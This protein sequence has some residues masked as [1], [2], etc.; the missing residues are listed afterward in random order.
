MTTD[1]TFFTNEP[2]ATLLDRFKRT[3]SDVQYFDV[4]VGYFRTSGFYQL[5]DALESVDHIRILV[6]L[7]VDQKAFEWIETA[8]AQMDLDFESHKRTKDQAREQVAAEITQ[9]QDTYATE[10]G[11]QKFIDFIRSGKLEI[12]AYPSANLHAKVYISRFGEEDRDFGR[13]ITGSSNFSWSGLV[14]NREFNVEL[15]DRADVEFALEQFEALWAEAV[16]ISADY[17]ATV[18][19]QTWL[20]DTITP[21]ELYLKFLYEYLKEDINLDEDDLDIYLPDSFMELAYQKQAV[22]SAKKILDAYGGV[23]LADVVGLGKTYISALLAQQIQG[24]ILVICPPVLQ[25]YWRETFYDF[26]I[27]GYEVE[28]LGKLDALLQRDL[29]KFRYVLIDEAHRFR[30]EGT[31]AYEN[32]F[33]ICAGKQVILVSATPLNNRISDI[34]NQLKLFQPARKSTIPGIANL[35]QFFKALQ[36]RLDQ[37]EKTDPEYWTTLKAVSQE[38]RTKVLRYVMVRRT[39]SEILNYF[40]EDLTQQGLMFPK[41]A[42]PQKIIYQFDDKTE[43]VFNQT[44]R[45]LRRLSYA[46]YTPLLYLNQQVSSFTRQSQRNIGGFMR[47]ILVKRLE[48]SFYAFKRTL[49]RFIESY[50]KFIAM[51]EQ[52]TV[53]IS[54]DLD[55]YDLLERDNPDELLTEVEQNRVQ[56]YQATD[57]NDD[58]LQ[59]LR[60]DLILLQDIQTLWHRLE[61][62]PKLNQFVADLQ[63]HSHL[64]DQQLVIFTESKETG[65]HLY[66]TLDAKFPHQVMFYASKGGVYNASG[67]PVYHNPSVAKTLIQQNFDPNHSTQEDRIRIL[68]TTDVLAEGINLHRANVVVNYDLPWNPTRVLQRVGRVNR[69]GTAHDQVYIFNCFPTAQSEAQLGLEENIVAKIQAFHDTLGEDAKYLSEEEEVTTHELFGDRLYHTLN[70]RESYE[71][72]TEAE[73]RSELEYLQLLRQIRDQQPHLFETIKKLPRKA[74][75]AQRIKTLT[76]SPSPKMGEGSK[77]LSSSLLSTQE[78]LSKS[79]PSPSLG[80]GGRGDEGQLLASPSLGEGSQEGQLLTFFRQGALKKFFLSDG[81]TTQEIDFF[82]AVDWLECEPDHPKQPIPKRYYDLLQQNKDAF[83][84]LEQMPDLAPA[85]GR[86]GSTYDKFVIQCLKAKDI[87]RFRGFTDEDEAFLKVVRIA[88]EEGRIPK[89]TAKKVQQAIKPIAGDPLKLLNALKRTV[90]IALLAEPEP[91]PIPQWGQ[92]REVVLSEYL[93][94]PGSPSP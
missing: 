58:F 13:V 33:Q 51:V 18:Q 77:K 12:K 50:E 65:D 76:P 40:A 29:K 82:Q 1:L 27:R 88:F 47:A 91:T 42:E 37:Y 62:D 89:P 72:G 84:A 20:N 66:A 24:R 59:D 94:P 90:P 34:F 52:G 35:E 22:T 6:G 74:R 85:L 80:E 4:L 17:V 45:L 68:I 2:G 32:L 61:D 44:M 81:T 28:S 30:N 39:R 79:P 21:Y 5:Y 46:R 53:L 70:R 7:T 93:Y 11:V 71:Q 19:Q 48:S 92:S 14:A 26:G 38:I 3:L 49:G 60:A 64:K 75:T 10:L 73:E 86:G 23:F 87:R 67:E 41:L 36:K 43:W 54:K 31:Q 57:F 69:V 16:D 9:A 78:I 83:V 63:S 55:V 8:Q 25:D 15:K 56:V